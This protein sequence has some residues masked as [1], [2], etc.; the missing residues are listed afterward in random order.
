MPRPFDSLKGLSGNDMTKTP[1]TNDIAEKP[2]KIDD[3]THDFL[4]YKVTEGAKRQ[5]VGWAKWSAGICAVILAIFGI[6]YQVSLRQVDDKIESAVTKRLEAILESKSDEVDRLAQ[7]MVDRHIEALTSTQSESSKVIE[8]LRE[9]ADKELTQLQK[10]VVAVKARLDASEREVESKK[11]IIIATWERSLPTGTASVSAPPSLIVV[12]GAGPGEMLL[13]AQIGGRYGSPFT[14]FFLTALDD[15]ASDLDRDTSVSLREAVIHAST[16]MRRD[17]QR[18]QNPTIEGSGIDDPFVYVARLKPEPR[19][20]KLFALLVGINEYGKYSLRGCVPDV[21]AF[22][23]YFDRQ[24]SLEV[25]NVKTL[26]DRAATKD[27]ILNEAKA[28]ASKA[29]ESDTVIVS[30]SGHFTSVE[31]QEDKPEQ[32]KV[33]LPVDFDFSKESPEVADYVQ[34]DVIKKIVQESHAARKILMMP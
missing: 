14:H 17:G 13:D 7:R 15:P 9:E 21:E 19:S 26:I 16:L 33:F 24:T 8:T 30:L 3:E 11:R 32:T 29:S 10:E 2:A 6:Q 34:L 31:T 28:L 12:S 27:S 22:A 20:G 4:V 25:G 1:P 5:I 23:D 18:T